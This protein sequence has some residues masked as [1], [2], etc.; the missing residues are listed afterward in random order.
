[1]LIVK[2]DATALAVVSK[3]FL[4][5][6]GQA[7][8]SSGQ[9]W[10]RKS[11]RKTE[12][13]GEAIHARF[14][15]ILNRKIEDATGPLHARIGKLEREAGPALEVKQIRFEMEATP[16]WAALGGHL[17]RLLPYAREFDH[18]VKHEV[19]NAVV[20]VTG[21]TR[22]GMPIDVARA[23]DSV[24]GELM[25][26]GGGGLLYPAREEISEDEQKLLER[27]EH[28]TFELTWDACRYLRDLKMVE[29]G[30]RLYWALIRFA[31][32]N[33]LQHL[34]SEFV[35]NARR[36]QYICTE[37]RSGKAFPEAQKQLEEQIADALDVPDRAERPVKLP[38][39]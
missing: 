29:V 19:L 18:V 2:P 6:Q 30:A 33:G 11:D 17:R 27:I 38:Q 24:L 21:R 15:D 28:A 39:A 8:L 9:C 26:V 12:L 34:Q 37:K 7:L 10:G 32:L 3:R 5:D 4:D 1:V 13:G 22:Q 31:A 20:E 25:P 16:E 14:R 36:C 35:N 23:V